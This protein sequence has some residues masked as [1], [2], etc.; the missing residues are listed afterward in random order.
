MVDGRLHLLAWALRSRWEHW[1]ALLASAPCSK[2]DRHSLPRVGCQRRRGLRSER[3]ECQAVLAAGEREGGKGQRSTESNYGAV[4]FT[5]P[6]VSPEEG[7]RTRP[8]RVQHAGHDGAPFGIEGQ[9][10]SCLSHEH[11]RSTANKWALRYRLHSQSAEYHLGQKSLNSGG[12]TS[13][14]LNRFQQVPEVCA[15]HTIQPYNIPAQDARSYIVV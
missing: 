9:R 15:G 6:C 11:G 13:L 7:G 2:R 3:L 10:L 14:A 12:N 8:R 4:E 5:W 1:C